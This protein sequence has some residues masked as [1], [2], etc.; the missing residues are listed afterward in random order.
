M[1]RDFEW[2]ICWM[3]IKESIE[4]LLHA[5]YNAGTEDIYQGV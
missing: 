4:C 5:K 1:V 3:K 2:N